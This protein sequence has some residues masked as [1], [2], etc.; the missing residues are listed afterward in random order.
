[1]KIEID[2]SSEIFGSKTSIADLAQFHAILEDHID[3]TPD[4]DIFNIRIFEL[5]KQDYKP[6][7]KEAQIFECDRFTLTF[8]DGSKLT[9]IR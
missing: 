7:I 5:M 8:K 4:T 3:D 9:V 6:E 2:N 1:M